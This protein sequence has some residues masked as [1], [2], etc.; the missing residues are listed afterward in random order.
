MPISKRSRSRAVATKSGLEDIK[1]QDTV[2][3]QESV[4]LKSP[5]AAS[6]IPLDAIKKNVY[7]KF[8]ISFD[9][10]RKDTIKDRNPSL[11]KHMRDIVK[12]SKKMKMMERAER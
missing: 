11:D 6:T 3:E 4:R 2:H 9:V 12:N 7:D 8:S 1:E 5:V 10:K